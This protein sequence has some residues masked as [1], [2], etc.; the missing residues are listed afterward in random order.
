MR[1]SAA[2][3]A[4]LRMAFPLCDV[5]TTAARTGARDAFAGAERGCRAG[6][7]RTRLP[8]PVCPPYD[9]PREGRMAFANPPR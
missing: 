2:I 8:A 6:W 1:T 7:R 4:V 3:D 5:R 9:R